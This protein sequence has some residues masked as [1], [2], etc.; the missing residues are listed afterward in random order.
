MH[1]ICAEVVIR[2]PFPHLQRL[3]V[4]YAACCARLQ[5]S[6]PMMHPQNSIP[7]TAGRIVVEL[8]YD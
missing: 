5:R 8:Q 1:G 3:E 7:M 4:R 2:M 6:V